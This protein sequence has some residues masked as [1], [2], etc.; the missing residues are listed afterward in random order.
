MVQCL[1]CLVANGG[2]RPFE[3]ATDSNFDLSTA[4]PS[5]PPFIA[6]QGIPANPEGF[7]DE[8]QARGWIQN[9]TERCQSIGQTLT[10]VDGGAT[11]ITATATTT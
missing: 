9:V 7:I 3:A 6:S 11:E 4:R 8:D 10:P 5:N 1:N 2:E